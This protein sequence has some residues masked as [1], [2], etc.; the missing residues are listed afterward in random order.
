MAKEPIILFRKDRSTED[1]FQIA[2]KYFEV[3]ESRVGINDRLVIPRYS[4]LPFF[5]E[6]ERD[7]K[8]QGSGLINSSLEHSY[9]ANFDYY[10]DISHLTAESWFQLQDVPKNDGPFVVKGRTNSRKFDWSTLMYAQSFQDLVRI[11]TELNKDSLISQQGLV[12]RK[13]IPLKTLEIGISGTPFANEWRFFFYQDVLLSEGFYWTISEKR[14]TLNDKAFE[15]ANAAAAVIKEHVNFFVL[16]LAEDVDGKW[17]VIEV[18]DG[19]QSG[20]SD[21]DADRLYKNLRNAID[22]KAV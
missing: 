16:D 1:E 14:G 6:L 11:T 12:Y 10:H 21:N 5:Y 9:I 3:T 19:Q 8:L 18:N 20:L 13:Y 22:S 7:L 4:A 15:L 17:W 2:K